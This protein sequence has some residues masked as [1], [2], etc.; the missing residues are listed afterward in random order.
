ME[1]LPYGVFVEHGFEMLEVYNGK[2]FPAFVA[3]EETVAVVEV[4]NKPGIRSIC[5]CRQIS[6]P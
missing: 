1:V 5:I 4:Q 6:V 3:S 2:T